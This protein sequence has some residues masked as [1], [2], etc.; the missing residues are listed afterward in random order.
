MMDYLFE[1]IGIGVKILIFLTVVHYVDL[2]IV[3]PY[4]KRRYIINKD[5]HILITGACMGIGR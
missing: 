2:L 1:F 5:T 3:C 4:R